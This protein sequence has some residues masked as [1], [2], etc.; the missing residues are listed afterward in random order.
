MSELLSASDEG[1]TGRTILKATASGV[2][3]MDKE[4]HVPLHGTT[5]VAIAHYLRE[6]IKII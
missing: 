3:K 1:D 4:L 2:P 5:P 6:N